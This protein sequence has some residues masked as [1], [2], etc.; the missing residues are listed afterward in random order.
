MSGM[1]GPW[2]MGWTHRNAEGDREQ[3]VALVKRVGD[4]LA[5]D[6]G[7][8]E[9]AERVW[10]EATPLVAPPQRYVVGFL[11]SNSHVLLLNKKRPAWQLDRLNGPGGH[12][13][14]GESFAEAMYR[15]FVEEVQFSV[16]DWEH[17]ATLRGVERDGKP[18]EVA[19]FRAGLLGARGAVI[20]QYLE[21]DERPEW[22]ALSAL[23][24]DARVLP[25]LRFL[26]PMARMTELRKDWPYVLV[27]GG[28]NPQERAS[29]ERGPAAADATGQP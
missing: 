4:T 26:I 20:H 13:E 16:F 18:Y 24:T 12:V 7:M 17:F 21:Y 27:E 29:E 25:N 14:V 19:F 28:P 6:E 15:E 8:D 23:E 3:F 22:V 2:M 10:A 1:P 5:D 9:L 11:F